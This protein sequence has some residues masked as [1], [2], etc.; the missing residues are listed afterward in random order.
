MSGSFW[1]PFR[2][3]DFWMNN[4]ENVLCQEIESGKPVLI[5]TSGDSMQPL[6]FHH[7]TQVVVQKTARP[8]KKGDLPLYRRPSGQFVLH[9]IIRVED[10]SYYTRGDNR[11][12]LEQ[13]PKD[14]V[15]A[16]TCQIYRKDQ[17]FSVQDGR[18]K[19]YVCFWN[20]IYPL[21]W[22]WIKFRSLKR[23]AIRNLC[24]KKANTGLLSNK[25]G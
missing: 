1:L 15:L 11:I 20:A 13:V 10:E 6:L 22:I 17:Q 18:Y 9:R 16:N 24:R 19:L 23:K 5:R 25:K 14:W 2:K 3:R 4:R 8:L 12:G 7:Q 21:R